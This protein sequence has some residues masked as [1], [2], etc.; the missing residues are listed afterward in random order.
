MKMTIG[1]GDDIAVL[2]GN[3]VCV[4]I[5]VYVRLAVGVGKVNSPQGVKVRRMLPSMMKLPA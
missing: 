1:Q 5:K 4:G 3:E 2:T